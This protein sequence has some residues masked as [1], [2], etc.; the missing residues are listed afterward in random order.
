MAKTFV[1]IE[2]L[3]GVT[4][5]RLNRPPAN[6]LEIESTTQLADSIELAQ[7]G[8][9]KAIV[10]TGS[11]D[12]FS[13]GLDLKVVPSYH[14]SRQRQLLD[15]F[16]RLVLNLYGCPLPTVAAINGHAVAAGTLLTLACDY[17]VGPTTQCRFGLPGAR[18]GIPYPFAAWMI[19]EAELAPAVRRMML[20]TARTFD[21]HEA[22]AK[23]VIDEVE[24]PRKVLDKA[25]EMATQMAE[26]PQESFAAV[27]L[28]LR[29]AVISQIKE[30][31]KG[32]SDP[33]LE[34]WMVA[35]R[36]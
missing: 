23:G 19:F 4:I 33:F 22:V 29:N 9:T 25:I 14:R 11:G 10:L 36:E 1:E 8:A 28:R 18:V 17:R 3:G 30:A 32:E 20:L 31:M 34:D 26:I 27:K 16:N 15:A 6:A 2:R 5:L 24:P 35:D 21:A 13:A 7:D 12:C